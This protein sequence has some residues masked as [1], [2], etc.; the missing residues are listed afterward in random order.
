MLPLDECD[1]DRLV[2]NEH[3]VSFHD[4]LSTLPKKRNLPVA[5]TMGGRAGMGIINAIALL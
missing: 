1:V 3:D 2:S 5:D 4:L